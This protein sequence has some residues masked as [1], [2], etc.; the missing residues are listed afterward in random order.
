MHKQFECMQKNTPNRRIQNLIHRFNTLLKL[1]TVTKTDF[2]SLKEL[3]ELSEYYIE[4]GKIQRASKVIDIGLKLYGNSYSLLILNLKL[5]IAKE[6]IVGGKKILKTILMQYP[7]NAE[8]WL[9]KSIL[10][11]YEKKFEEAH[12]WIRKAQKYNDYEDSQYLFVPIGLVY[13]KMHQYLDGALLLKKF[14]EAYEDTD[15][16]LKDIA[17]AYYMAKKYKMSS[18]YYRRYLDKF[19]FDAEAWFRYGMNEKEQDKDTALVCFE[20]SLSIEPEIIEAYLQIGNIALEKKDYNRALENYLEYEKREQ[21]PEIYHCLGKASFY[22]QHFYLAKYFLQ[23]AYREIKSDDLYYHLAYTYLK[24]GETDKASI[25]VKKILDE[26]DKK[27][28]F[29]N[30]AG[31]IAQAEGRY[32]HAEF[33]FNEALKYNEDNIDY[34]TDLADLFYAR[35]KVLE[36]FEVLASANLRGISSYKFD[37]RLVLFALENNIKLDTKLLLD[38]ALNK[39]SR[40]LKELIEIFPQVQKYRMIQEA[41]KSSNL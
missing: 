36:A 6:N 38:T 11:I 20:Y 10:A 31:K 41:L 32:E 25:L 19:P 23:Q 7:P 1:K 15:E 3:E 35:N 17:E 22:T 30:L 39:N 2:L 28:K 29:W 27:H 13:L 24:T 34:W 26:D 8:L 5:E 9:F 12:K 16:L 14:Q 40:A 33:L 21:S 4:N 37:Y 18:N